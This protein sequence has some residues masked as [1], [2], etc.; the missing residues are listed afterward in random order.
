MPSAGTFWPRA[1]ICLRKNTE[2][3]FCLRFAE[4]RRPKVKVGRGQFWF[5]PPSRKSLRSNL[6]YSSFV[7]QYHGGSINDI[8]NYERNVVLP[9]AA[10]RLQTMPQKPYK[11]PYAHLF[12]TIYVCR[13]DLSNNQTSL[14]KTESAVL[15]S[16]PLFFHV[17]DQKQHNF[18]QFF[19]KI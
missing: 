10:I 11:P 1:V 9:S 18:D 2:G 13:Q 7:E 19:Q 6:Q 14:K 4:G 15:I 3:N 5:G 8:E 17:F 12:Q 16:L